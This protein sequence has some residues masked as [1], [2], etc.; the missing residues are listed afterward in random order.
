[1][2]GEELYGFQNI[3]V[4]LPYLH[5]RESYRAPREIC[6]EKSRK[7][8]SPEL[9]HKIMICEFVCE[10]VCACV[11]VCAACVCECGVL[12]PLT[13]L[14]FGVLPAVTRLAVDRASK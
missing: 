11:C 8:M 13:K 12:L 7:P 9:T 1:M 14:A 10:S 2:P 5:L 4:S 6:D 3:Q